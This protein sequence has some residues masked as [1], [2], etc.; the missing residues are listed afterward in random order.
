LRAHATGDVERRHQSK[1]VGGLAV[2]VVVKMVAM[3]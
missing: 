1:G 3:A 2:V